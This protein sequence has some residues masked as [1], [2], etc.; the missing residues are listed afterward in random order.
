MLDDLVSEGATPL[1]AEGAGCGFSELYREC[2]RV[3]AE[4]VLDA[5]FGG[6]GWFAIA[7]SCDSLLRELTGRPRLDCSASC[8]ATFA[9]LFEG[10]REWF[11]EEVVC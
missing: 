10:F 5:S 6:V 2:P 1:A 4:L 11:C 8:R 3:W 7:A 9:R